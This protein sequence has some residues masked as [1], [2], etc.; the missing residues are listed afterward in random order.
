[1]SRRP[2]IWRWIGASVVLLLATLLLIG[3]AVLRT[4]WFANYVSGKIVSVTEESTGGRAELG[5]FSFDW[6]HLHARV[7]G[8][9]LHGKEPSGAAPL[10]RIEAIELRLRLLPSFKKTVDLEYLGLD[11]PAANV[12]VFADGTTNVPEPRVPSRS[13]KSALET[14]VDLAIHRFDLNHGS[15]TF[16]EQKVP[17]TVH[18]RDLRAQLSFNA[19]ASMYRG[20]VGFKSV[21]LL[22]EGR[23]AMEASVNVPV[24]IGKDR[25]EIDKATVATAASSLT[26]SGSLA[27]LQ[28][29]VVDAHAVAHVSLADVRQSTGIASGA[30]VKER[31][32]FADIDVQAHVDE[33]KFAI[34]KAAITMGRSRLNASGNRDSVYLEGKFAMD[35]IG[36]IFQFSGDS[37]GDVQLEGVLKAESDRIDVQGIRI[38]AL[39]G[40]LTVDGTLTNYKAFQL[41]AK[42]GGY[43]I[44]DLERRFL[45]AKE[46]Y[47]GTIG[48][49][50]DALGDFSRPGTSGISARARLEIVP[51][52]RGVSLRGRVDADYEGAAN[53]VKIAHASISLPH[54]LLTLT[55]VLG[56]RIDA[57]FTT[58]D[59]NDLYPAMAMTMTDPPREIPLA[60]N[61][62]K[63][64]LH[65][66]ADGP[67]ASASI[68]GTVNADRFAWEKRAFDHLSADI[69]ASQR[70]VSIVNSSLTRG[71][72]QASVSGSVGL[73][74]WALTNDQ[75]LKA[76]AEMRDAELPDL[77]ALAGESSIPAT[78]KLNASFQAD[79]TVGNP[80]GTILISAADGSVYN[81]KFQTVEVQATMSDQLIRLTRADWVGPAG[82]IQA[83]GTY[84]HP[85]DTMLAG[86]V[87]LHAASGG[88]VQ[89]DA[90]TN[91][92]K[93]HAGING[94]L[95]LNLDVAGNVRQEKDGDA[96]ILSSI[97]GD[98]RA[99]DI[100]DRAKSYGNVSA[101]IDTSGS[102]ASFHGDSNLSGSS[103]HLTGQTKLAKDYPTTVDISAQNLAVEKLPFDLGVPVTGTVVLSGHAQ[104]TLHDP[105]VT[106][107]F[108]FS[109]GTVQGEPIDRLQASARYTAQLVEISS[110]QVNTPAGSATLRGSFTHP[111]NQ[112]ATGALQLHLASSDLRLDQIRSLQEAKPGLGGALKFSVDYAGDL[113]TIK[114]QREITASQVAATAD[115]VGAT[116]AGHPA[117]NAKLTAKTSGGAVNFAVD[118]NLARAAIHAQGEVKLTEDYPVTA[119]FSARDLHFSNLEPFLNAESIAPDF[120][121]SAEIEGSVSGSMRKLDELRGVLRIPSF[122]ASARTRGIPTQPASL[123]LRNEGPIEAQ[124]SRSALTIRSARIVG[125][126]GTDIGISGTVRFAEKNPLNLTIKAAADLGLLQDIDHDFYSS[127]SISLDA[128]VRGSFASPLANG[129][130]QLKSASVNMT[131]IS[132]G[133]SNANGMIV[134]NGS[135]ATIRNLTAESGG[136][137]ITL[138]GFAGFSGSTL[139]YSVKVNA[140]RVRTRQQGVSIVNNA[141]LTVSGTSQQGLISGTVTVVSVG[142]N[143]QSDLGS[144]LD[145]TSAAQA[146]SGQV[147]PFLSNT[148]L[149][150][151]IRTAPNVRFQ[152]SLAQD[153][154]AEADLNLVGTLRHPGMT[155]RVT[156]TEGDLIFFGNEYNVNHGVISF[157][158]PLKLDPQLDVSLETTVQSIDVVLTLKGPIDNL[159]LSYR[160]DPPIQ[161]EEIVA[162]LAIG[163]QPTSDPTIVANQIPPPQQSVGQMGETAVVSQAIAAPVSSR[164]ERVFGVTQLKIDP[165]FASGSALPQASLT[166]QQRVANN[167]TFTYTQDYSQPNSELVRVEWTLSRRFSAVATRDINGIFGVDFFYKR[168]FR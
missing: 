37:I 9:V 137:K 109:H 162:L 19:V 143:P 41:H 120:E 110:L 168:Q 76:N 156:V 101:H 22:Q 47:A 125:P 118:S 33:Q 166:L 163:R 71:T 140:T 121:A 69:T 124:L 164:L 75:P 83:S 24:T 84:T 135:T 60:L 94:T 10:L 62:G 78:G 2:R 98:V 50:I 147:S 31:P 132:N 49:A 97:R 165:T 141:A 15:V 105:I 58:T 14:I 65:A 88:P 16:A 23:P 114:G 1:M 123:A 45:S 85:R 117:G 35:E 119:Q 116:Y 128:A 87:R 100:R 68:S 59:P 136:G 38:D 36:G 91:L 150:I 90:I 79:G 64:Q 133:M 70:A 158:N 122:L 96:F 99:D 67:L 160:S 89:L 56:T 25:V 8:F 151:R 26:V 92:S 127:G 42:I 72:L 138:T 27:N 55:G 18:G 54:S 61:G 146:D 157:Y 154:E 108:D 149:D 167:V 131:S 152:S 28:N 115:L 130:L 7:T 46:G 86:D 153:L 11:K 126:R 74:N 111:A 34:Q 39:G 80:L 102:I 53:L 142:I 5:T 48:G 159:K 20:D 139:R 134:L 17:L 21:Q 161:F 112:F 129:S 93:Q 6:R 29:P 40:A 51:G 148:R 12:I 66:Q 13:N 32:C 3:V 107:Q 30:C 95:Q 43:E 155:G 113:K 145:S 63:V 103:I 144:I 44:A 104:G 106:V 82:T 73:R 57:D 81:E 77:L 52:V 4:A